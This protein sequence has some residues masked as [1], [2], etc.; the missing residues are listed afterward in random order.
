MKGGLN[1]PKSPLYPFPTLSLY[2]LPLFLPSL[3]SHPSFLSILL[4]PPLCD[5]IVY[6]NLFRLFARVTDVAVTQGNSS[7]NKSKQHAIWMERRRRRRR[8]SRRSRRSRRRRQQ[9]K[10]VCCAAASKS[11][12]LLAAG[13]SQDILHLSSRHPPRSPSTMGPTPSPPSSSPSP[14]AA[15]SDM[16][17]KGQDA[18]PFDQQGIGCS[19]A[20][21]SLARMR[22]ISAQKLP[23]N[24]AYAPS[25]HPLFTLYKTQIHEIARALISRGASL[26]S[27][28]VRISQTQPPN[29]RHPGKPPRHLWPYST[30]FKSVLLLTCG[31]LGV[32]WPPDS[33]QGANSFAG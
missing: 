11:G 22:E 27:E 14:P 2:L 23:D 8:R 32:S 20:L 16:P 3:P 9:V 24:P 17:Q 15:R 6:E 7:L 5:C 1:S 28:R 31:F 12:P 30:I 13:D 26:Y 18:P 21:S 29:G 25:F 4:S 19:L 10:S 33:N